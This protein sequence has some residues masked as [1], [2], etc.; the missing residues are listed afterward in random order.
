MKVVFN[1]LSAPGLM[2]L[3]GLAF[4]AL[5]LSPVAEA[6]PDKCTRLVPTGAREN[7]INECSKCRIVNITRKRPGNEMPVTRSFNI[8]P[9]S[10]ITVPFLG[11]GRSRITSELPCKG[12]PGAAENLADPNPRKKK[13]PETCVGMQRSLGGGISLVNKCKKCK[14]ALIERQSKAGGEGK[15][16]AYRVSPQSAIEVLSNGAAKIALLAEVDCP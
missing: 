13:A 8:Q 12:E 5:V 9:K 10:Q 4:I 15:R 7:L 16:Q 6:A 11:P 3:A 1:A 2:L 14:A